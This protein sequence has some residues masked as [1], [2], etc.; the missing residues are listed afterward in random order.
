MSFKGFVK[1]NY[2]RFVII[3]VL[4]IICGLSIIGAGYIQMYWLTAIKD[5]KWRDAI[6]YILLMVISWSFTY[7]FIKLA[8]YLNNKQ[9]EEYYKQIRDRIAV[10]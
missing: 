3:T 9:E 7:V 5:E 1:V 8:Q 2:F 6:L 10:H 4:S